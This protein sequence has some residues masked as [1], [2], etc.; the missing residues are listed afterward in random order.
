MIVERLRKAGFKSYIVGG[1]VRDMVMGFDPKDYDISTDASPEDVARL[2]K[3]VHQVGAQFGVSM[4]IVDKKAYEVARFRTDGVYEDGRRPSHIEPAGEFEDIQRRDFT[5][6]ALMY[7]PFEDRILDN[8]N[9]INDIHN[10][11]IRTVGDPFI[12]F[13]E[14]RLRMLRAVRFAAQF[15]FSIEPGTMESLKQL[16]STIQKISNERIGE[17]LEKIFTGSHPGK[18]LVLLDETGLLGEVL[19]EVKAMKNVKQ[20]TQFHPE[21]DVFEHTRIMLEM[22]GG[23]STTLAFGILLHDVGKPVT[24]SKTDRIR[25]NNHDEIGAEMAVCILKHLRYSRDVITRVK[26]FVKNH[27]RFI[28]AKEMRRSTLRRFMA[29]EGFDELLELYRL[30]CMAS[31]GSLDIYEY[32]KNQYTTNTEQ[33][34]NSALPEPLINGKDLIKLGYKPG[35]LFSTILKQVMDVQLEG[36]VT[37]RREAISFLKRTFPRANPRQNHTRKRSPL[38][39]QEFRDDTLNT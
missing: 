38:D 16:A 18:A 32:V 33:T 25:F 26:S 13:S 23:G 36:T 37:T 3:K 27:M 11:I 4:V 20:P 22:F 1:A 31:H 19:P 2:F 35:P 9:G 15:D 5:I 29:T 28:H 10:C 17:E 21:G 30:D 8:V 24:F 6:N 39:P 34:R 14:D 12:R 7:D